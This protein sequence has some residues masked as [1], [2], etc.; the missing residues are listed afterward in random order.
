MLKKIVNMIQLREANYSPINPYLSFV[1]QLLTDYGQALNLQ[2]AVLCDL[3]NVL[4]NMSILEI[5]DEEVF[6]D[7]KKV[8]DLSF[9]SLKELIMNKESD[10]LFL[11]KYLLLKINPEIN[12]VLNGLDFNQYSSLYDSK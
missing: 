12:S 4:I 11:S 7:G 2:F 5:K 10:D 6:F 1:Q 9:C 8:D 3:I